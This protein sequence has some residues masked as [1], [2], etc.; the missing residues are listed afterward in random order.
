MTI[1]ILISTIV[2]FVAFCFTYLPLYG[3]KHWPRI[4][5]SVTCFVVAYL[6]IASVFSPIGSDKERYIDSFHNAPS[7]EYSKDPGWTVLTKLLHV[8]CFDNE[9]LYLLILALV[10]VLAYYSL[11]KYKFG[12]EN[13]VYYL[14]LSAG[15][16]GFWSGSTNIIRAGLATALFFYSLCNEDRNKIVYGILSLAAFF[17]HNSVLILIVSF[18]ITKYFH[19]Y[20]TYIV[21]WLLFLILSAANALSPIVSFLSAHTG[22]VGDRLA[23]YAYCNDSDVADVYRNTG[24]RIDFILYSALVIIY[25]AWIIIKN[26]YKD[27]FY[28]RIVCTYILTNCFWLTMI[29]A[30]Y[31]DRFALLSWSLI[32]FIIL[33]PYMNKKNKLVM[34]SWVITIAFLPVILEFILMMRAL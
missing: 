10:Y 4:S 12:K 16:L 13:I 19:N 17:V 28:E 8:I 31:S 26:G 27:V 14:L 23:E 33:Y 18:F 34:N 2:V 3:K 25:S 24:F 22:E 1:P 15:C 7:I 29:R 30:F 21:V 11:G 32:S 6:V 5:R 20:K 9:I